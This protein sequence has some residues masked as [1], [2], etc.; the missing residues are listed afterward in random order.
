MFVRK[1]GITKKNSSLVNALMEVEMY[2]ISSAV[3]FTRMK[4]RC[5]L[6]TYLGT[7]LPVFSIGV[8]ST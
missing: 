6:P 2:E 8:G 4:G 1:Q 5:V 3:S 7:Y